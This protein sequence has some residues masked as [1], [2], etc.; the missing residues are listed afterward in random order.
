M[1]AGKPLENDILSS[2]YMMEND[3]L[4][5]DAFQVIYYKIYILYMYIITNK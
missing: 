3:L 1:I 5:L 2:I 4:K